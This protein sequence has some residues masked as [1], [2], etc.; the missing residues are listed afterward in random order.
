MFPISTCRL[1]LTVRNE[2]SDEAGGSSYDVGAGKRNAS[3]D[4][5][6]GEDYE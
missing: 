6:N 3:A 1:G 4:A 5:L 2:G